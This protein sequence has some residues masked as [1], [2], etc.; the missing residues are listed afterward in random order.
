MAAAAQAGGR[1]E[2]ARNGDAGSS[3]GASPRWHRN[4]TNCVHGSGHDNGG[5]SGAMRRQAGDGKEQRWLRATMIGAAQAADNDEGGELTTA[6][7]SY[8]DQRV[9]SR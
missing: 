9:T 3:S 6:G 2:K 5:S 7:D 8:D 1:K 4:L